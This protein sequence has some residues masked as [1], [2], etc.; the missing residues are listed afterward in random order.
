M[1]EMD[2]DPSLTGA[3]PVNPGFSTIRS[4]EDFTLD[5]AADRT[6]TYDTL[7]HGGRRITEVEARIVEAQFRLSDGSTLVL[8][9]DDEPFREMLTLVLVG[10]DLKVRDRLQLGGAFTPGFLTYAYPI[11]ENEIAFCWHDLDQVVTIE[12][13]KR[14]LGLRSGWLRVREE[15]VQPPRPPG[16]ALPK[17]GQ[18]VPTIRLPSL[19]RVPRRRGR[20][21]PSLVWLAWLSMRI[22][23]FGRA[24][25]TPVVR[26]RGP[27]R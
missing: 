19:A 3:A 12:R 6:K 8:L 16:S 7:L 24:S 22:F 18:F 1:A 10:P 27:R 15:A 13:Y 20:A 4:V 17:L 21:M 23:R 14:R 25:R 9:N 11:G 2:I 5:L 26:G